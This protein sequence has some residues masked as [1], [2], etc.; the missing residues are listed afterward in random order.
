[1]DSIS[2]L[3]VFT[4]SFPEGLAVAILGM[5]AIGKH[6]LFRSKE[7]YLRVFLFALIYASASFVIRRITFNIFESAIVFLLLTC[8]MLMIVVKLN[9][10][11]SLAASFLGLYVI[12]F[13]VATLGMLIISIFF[14]TNQ[15]DIFTNDLLR[16]ELSLPQRIFEILLAILFYNT[17]FKIMK[18]DNI[19]LKKREYI[20]QI[21]VYLISLCTFIFL[22]FILCNNLLFNNHG[23]IDTQNYEMLRLNVY[24]SIFVVILLTLAIKAITDHYKAK[25]RLSNTEIL[26]NIEYMIHLIDEKKYNDAKEIAESIKTHVSTPD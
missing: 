12:Q 23:L 8:V 14:N 16:F 9:F 1:M 17:K 11:E 10:Y 19:N 25:S 5:L 3:S 7:T 26:Q 13:I 15:V 21:I 20:V 24:L 4:V 18:F 2:I 22:V 6:D